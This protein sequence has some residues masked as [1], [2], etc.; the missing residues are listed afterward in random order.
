MIR[1]LR[2][3]LLLLLGAAITIA[4]VV[5]FITS[6]RVATEKA[7]KLFDY[8]MQQMAIA[9]EDS[10]FE[11]AAW[12]KMSDSDDPGFD[13]VI[14]IWTDDGVRVYQSRTYR[15]L[16]PRTALGYSNVNLDNG[17]W[18][19]YTVQTDTRVV[20]VSQKMQARHDRAFALAL[21]AVWPVLP[22]SLLLFAAAWWVVTTAL[23]PLNRI[24]HD[25][26]N[27]NADS[28]AP[29]SD[30][31]VPQ[32]VSLLV[33][34]LNLLLARMSQSLESQ[35][36][37][38]ADA[39]HELRSPLTALK[40][41]VQTLA[42]AKDDNA[43]EHGIARLLGGVDRASRLVEQLLALARQDPSVK[44]FERTEVSLPA[45][46]EQAATDVAPLALARHIHLEYDDLASA[47]IAGDLDSLRMMM[48]NLV[49]NAVRYT[50]EHGRIRIGLAT[51]GDA[52]VL[53]IEDSG[54]GIPESDRERVFDR[55]YR[56]PGTSASGS[57]LGLAIAKAIA[58][59]HQATI[60]LGESALGG[61][62]V[63]ITF[64]PII[65]DAIATPSIRTSSAAAA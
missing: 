14:Q 10:G 21:S 1:S 26:A 65:D 13:F 18:R 28:L 35:Q 49:D 60:E 23:S 16:P 64:R 53:R 33:G 50:P 41:Q 31:G 25:L 17:D 52:A 51:E 48:R 34:E 27:R 15:S 8:H 32:E 63:R 61:L 11:S 4:A 6:F 9:L 57:G 24:G 22:V 62:A 55:F 39:A 19:V 47:I 36:R 2:V 7:D 20:Q 29:V 46:I 54:R 38:V 12:P 56:V 42:R 59:R 3:R 30:E 43:R 5:Q 58:D 45:C 37:F 44:D 40:L